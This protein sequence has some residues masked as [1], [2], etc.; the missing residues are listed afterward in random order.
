MELAER[1][2]ISFIRAGGSQPV[3]VVNNQTVTIG[4]EVNGARVMAISPDNV[5][6]QVGDSER[7]ITAW[8]SDAVRRPAAAGMEGMNPMQNEE[9]T[10]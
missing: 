2:R 7:H 5:V 4:D 1:Y 3:A 6:L 10:R 9:A 8:H